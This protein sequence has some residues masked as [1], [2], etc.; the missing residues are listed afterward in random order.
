MAQASPSESQKWHVRAVAVTPGGAQTRSKRA[1]KFPWAPKVLT[2]GDG[3]KIWDVEGKQYIDWICGLAAVSLGHGYTGEGRVCFPSPSLVTRQEILTAEKVCDVLQ[4][5]QVRFVKTGSEATE[6][7]MRMARLATGRD[8]IVQI[9]YHGWHSPHDAALPEPKGV[10]DAYKTVDLGWPW[11]ES[12]DIT[13][14]V[15]AVLVE[16]CRDE[17]PPAGYLQHLRHWCTQNGALLI[18]DDVVTGFRWAI[19]G[20]SEYFGVEP[21]LRCYGKGMAN[22]YPLACIVGRRDLMKHAEYVSGTFGGETLSLAAASATIDVY[23]SEPVIEHMWKTGRTLM[24]GFNKL[25]PDRLK[26]TGYPVHPKIVGQES[27]DFIGRV[28]EEGVLFHPAGFNISYSHREDEVRET[29]EACERAL[30]YQSH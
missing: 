26:M 23:R 7:A 10:P 3:A 24:D 13:G 14:E 12:L 27:W 29:L 9:G 4:A 22:G 25:A 2:V 5:D 28:A 21:D 16:A 19:R 8:A 30:N 1:E 11:G 15:A 17:E 6:G 18:F 20:A